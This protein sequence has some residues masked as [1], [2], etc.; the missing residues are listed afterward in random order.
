MNHSRT[1]H[2]LLCLVLLGS[3][4]IAPV[5]AEQVVA[6]APPTGDHLLPV[7]SCPPP[8]PNCFVCQLDIFPNGQ[9]VLSCER[10][11]TG[12]SHCEITVE[13]DTISCRAFGPFCDT[14]T[15]EG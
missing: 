3:L 9:S 12:R 2:A 6:P 4:F 1:A 11:D 14:I 5:G 7:E 8:L 15:V 10:V 13:D